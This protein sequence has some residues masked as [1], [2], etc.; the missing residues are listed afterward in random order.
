MTADGSAVNIAWVAHIFGFIS[1]FYLLSLL[2]PPP[3]S[4]SGGPGRVDYGDWRD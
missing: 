3:M 4:A 2:D 1:G